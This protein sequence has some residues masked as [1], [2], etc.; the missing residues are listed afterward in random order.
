MLSQETR[1]LGRNF[2]YKLDRF[3]GLVAEGTGI[4]ARS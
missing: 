1:R 2:G 3:A 4:A